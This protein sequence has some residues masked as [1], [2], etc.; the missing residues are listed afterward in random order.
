MLNEE[1]NISLNVIKN[2]VLDAI[3]VDE[4]EQKA[5]EFAIL[6][7][8][9]QDFLRIVDINWQS[10]SVS[11]KLVLLQGIGLSDVQSLNVIKFV[12][13][14]LR[15][16]NSRVRIQAIT[17]LM[18]LDSGN[19]TRQQLKAHLMTESELTVREI[20]EDALTEFYYRKK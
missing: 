13:S 12:R 17:S 11:E 5:A 16:E 8:A 14:K 6:F 18:N 7:R 1:K 20:L 19:D 4:I 3:R 2:L 9:N 10:F 15:D